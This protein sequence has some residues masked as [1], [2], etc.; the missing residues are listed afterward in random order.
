MPGVVV[1]SKGLNKWEPPWY[2]HGVRIIEPIRRFPTPRN[3]A[4]LL[5]VW[6]DKAGW[7]GLPSAN[8][9]IEQ[10][11]KKSSRVSGWAFWDLSERVMGFE[12]TTLYLGSKS[13]DKYLALI[14]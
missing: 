10:T 7:R 1:Q 9:H 2:N 14:N 4:G 13:V 12:P 3:Y 6:K 5:K 11:I 8:V